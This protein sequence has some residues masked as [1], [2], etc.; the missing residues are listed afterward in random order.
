[1]VQPMPT[2]AR[3]FVA[4]H[5][6]LVGSAIVR[7]LE[8]AGYENLLLARRRELD[9]RDQSAVNAWMHEHRPE[10][11]FLVAGTVGGIMANSTRPA[12]FIYDNMM[13]HATVVHAAWLT[14]VTK[15]LYLGS[16]CIYPR[17]AKQPITEDELL[18]GVLEPTNEPYAIAK[19]AGI[20]L[21]QAYKRQYGCNFI[22]AMPTNL[23][24]PGDNFD[25]TSSHVLPAMIRKFDDAKRE[26][27]T[28]V[29][30]WGTGSPMRE[31]LHVDDLADACVFLMDSYENDLHINVGTGADL[32]IRE[33][34]EMVRDIVHPS[35]E[36]V[37]DTSKPDG[38]PRKVLDV[39]RLTGLGWKPSVTLRE[40]IEGTY[41]WYLDNPDSIRGGH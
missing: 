7:R 30:I 38:T 14:G 24:G 20:K 18:T 41:R 15:L 17:H 27:R 32:T 6:G 16:S 1:V 31:F 26:G 4:G 21:C 9:L 36:L 3:I 22:S 29:E 13:I 19:I 35:A 33:L 40:G 23:Y 8:S 28:N 39:S 2:D 12:E 11:V 10:Y 37:F 34:A 25:L 5:A